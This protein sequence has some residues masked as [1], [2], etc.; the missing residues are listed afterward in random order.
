MADKL[1][2]INK[3]IILIKNEMIPVE[4]LNIAFRFYTNNL[5]QLY[6]YIY[7]HTILMAFIK[8]N[9]FYCIHLSLK[10]TEYHRL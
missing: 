5:F 1:Y 4:N 3:Y 8:T 2:V 10:N 6:I 7:R 9:T